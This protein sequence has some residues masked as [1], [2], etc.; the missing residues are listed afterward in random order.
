MDPVVAAVV[1]KNVDLDDTVLLRLQQRV[2]SAYCLLFWL[3][4]THTHTHTRCLASGN[5][6][7]MTPNQRCVECETFFARQYPLVF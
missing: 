2:I 3:G 7:T 4:R 6:E 5:Q 1:Y